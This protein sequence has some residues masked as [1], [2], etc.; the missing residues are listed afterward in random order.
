[1]TALH[2]I[3]GWLC[4]ASSALKLGTSFATIAASRSS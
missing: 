2:V 1:M 3:G 4:D